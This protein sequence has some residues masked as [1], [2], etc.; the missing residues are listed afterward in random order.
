MPN[1]TA[2]ASTSGSSVTSLPSATLLPWLSQSH[3][4]VLLAGHCTAPHPHSHGKVAGAGGG[5]T[6]RQL[7]SVIFAST[8]SRSLTPLRSG[9]LSTHALKTGSPSW[10]PPRQVKGT[11]AAASALCTQLTN[12]SQPSPVS[13]PSPPPAATVE[14]STTTAADMWLPSTGQPSCSVDGR[15]RFSKKVIELACMEATPADKGARFLNTPSKLLPP[16]SSCSIPLAPHDRPHEVATTAPLKGVTRACTTG[17]LSTATPG[18]HPH[19]SP[20]ATELMSVVEALMVDPDAPRP[21]RRQVKGRKKLVVRKAMHT[22]L[23]SAARAPFCGIASSITPATSFHTQH[24]VPSKAASPAGAYVTAVPSSIVSPAP[25]GGAMLRLATPQSPLGGAE[26]SGIP[27]PLLKARAAV[28]RGL[29]TSVAPA[30]HAAAAT[31]TGSSPAASGVLAPLSPLTPNAACGSRCQ[32]MELPL[33]FQGFPAYSRNPLELNISHSSHGHSSRELTP[34][35]AASLW[36][37]SRRAESLASLHSTSDRT[38]APYHF[39]NFLDG[40]TVSSVG[41]DDDLIRNAL[42]SCDVSGDAF[43]DGVTYEEMHGN[44]DECDGS[45]RGVFQRRRVVVAMGALPPAAAKPEFELPQRPHLT[46]L[47]GQCD[48]HASIT[49]PFTADEPTMRST[50]PELTLSSLIAWHVPMSRVH[51][52]DR[53]SSASSYGC[54][55]SGSTGRSA[56]A[57]STL[58]APSHS[59]I[60]GSGYLLADGCG[61]ATESAISSPELPVFVFA[62]CSPFSLAPHSFGDG[63]GSRRLSAEVGE[64]EDATRFQEG[65]CRT[66]VDTI[67]R[68][69]PR[70][71][72]AHRRR[73]SDGGSSR[74]SLHRPSSGA[75]NA[76]ISAHDRH[77]HTDRCPEAERRARSAED[78]SDSSTGRGRGRG[79]HGDNGSDGQSG[80]RSVHGKGGGHLS[81]A[82]GVRS[83][84]RPSSLHLRSP[85]GRQL[86]SAT[87]SLAAAEGGRVAGERAGDD[88]AADPPERVASTASRLHTLREAVRFMPPATHGATAAAA[89]NDWEIGSRALHARRPPAASSARLPSA[90]TQHTQE[91]ATIPLGGGD[92]CAALSPSR[93]CCSDYHQG[94][95]RRWRFGLLWI[96]PPYCAFAVLLVLA[97][98]V[99]AP[100][101]ST[102]AV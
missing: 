97:A 59:G 7:R 57:R 67:Q 96:V 73:C 65:S 20:S 32:Q 17:P 43:E 35:L 75:L 89:A 31:A 83:V 8:P 42:G 69:A 55:G 62:L 85:S 78:G 80:I 66:T 3:N 93:Q 44:D 25:P 102:G 87:A 19:P 13:A 24:G 58:P 23:A 81:S 10:R 45:S 26:L 1:E 38:D 15:H 56:F 52:T 41:E 48:R 14:T 47:Q 60:A 16:G 34:A 101:V 39:E 100:V 27:A 72:C 40:T 88:P 12:P 49:V 36:E 30:S 21:G 84:S 95:Q 5:A 22:D 98:L 37:E 79:C 9:A 51:T 68:G 33:Y 18:H 11:N 86:K 90:A 99:A 64:G 92:G 63:T 71:R 82:Q 77:S 2:S 29:R 28:A 50:T 53:S 54:R 6:S 91:K 46:S 4:E 70:H 61:G 94:L 74:R 76:P